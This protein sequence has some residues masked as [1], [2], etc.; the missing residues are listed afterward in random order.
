MDKWFE[1][2]L[3]FIVVFIGLIVKKLFGSWKI[4]SRSIDLFSKTLYYVFFPVIFYN[5]FA[6]RGVSIAD[7][8]ITCIALSYV[9]FSVILLKLSFSRTNNVRLANAFIITAV[10]QNNVFLG[11]PILLTL[12]G[13]VE[14]ASMYSLVMLILH[15]LT[16]NLLAAK[17]EQLLKSI[18]SIPVLYGF[19]LGNIT[20]YLFIEIYD[21]TSVINNYVSII[22]TYGAAFVLGYSLPLQIRELNK[23]L[24]PLFFLGLY[25]FVIS[26]LLHMVLLNVFVI[27]VNGFYQLIVEALMPPALMNTVI[28]R[29]YNWDYEFVSI[30]TLITTFISIPLVF[31]L[32][33]LG[34][35]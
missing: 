9:V 3:L 30:S 7:L 11:F 23:W 8:S 4:F 1:I 14:Y 26:P 35:I 10:F 18:I 20:H 31:S 29:I 12:Y 22:L 25:R 21:F 17:R 27:P 32:Y 15:I 34:I 6:A 5:T 28:S 16:A 33:F 24:K 13:S 19:I 2:A